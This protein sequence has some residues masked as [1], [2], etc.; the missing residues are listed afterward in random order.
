MSPSYS[1]SLSL[2]ALIMA[3]SLMYVSNDTYWKWQ[4]G[5]GTH[6]APNLMG[7]PGPWGPHQLSLPTKI[8]HHQGKMTSYLIHN[9]MWVAFSQLRSPVMLRCCGWMQGCCLS[10][11]WC[12]PDKVASRNALLKCLHRSH[13]TNVIKARCHHDT[14]RWFCI[15]MP[16]I[17]QLLKLLK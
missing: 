17:A 12:N 9:K 7:I 3:L 15:L 11:F 5:T 8:K 14:L 13:R 2:S 10:G 4:Y 16:I 6:W 1:V